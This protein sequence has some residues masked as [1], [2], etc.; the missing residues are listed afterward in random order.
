MKVW[1]YLMSTKYCIFGPPWFTLVRPLALL[2]S[3]ALVSVC[4]F[5][6]CRSIS[7]EWQNS[8]GIAWKIRKFWRTRSIELKFDRSNFAWSRSIKISQNL[9]L[10][11]RARTPNQ[12]HLHDKKQFSL[13]FSQQNTLVPWL[14]LSLAREET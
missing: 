4:V 5:M 1:G 11:K 13:W 7:E 8:Y 12:E 2:F 3:D 6:F 9:L 10:Q 14:W